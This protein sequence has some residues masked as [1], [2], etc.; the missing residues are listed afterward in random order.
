M[1]NWISSTRICQGS[2]EVTG[3]QV[4]TNCIISFM[5]V[6]FIVRPPPLASIRTLTLVQASEKTIKTQLKSLQY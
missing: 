4:L 2:E 5:E 3:S 1:C 6:T